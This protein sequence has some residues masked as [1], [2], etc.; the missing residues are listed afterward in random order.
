M[1]DEEVL[2][3]TQVA[4]M[5]R[6]SRNSVLNLA[7]KNKLKHFKIGIQYRFVKSNVERFMGI[8]K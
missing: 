6:C 2:T 5:L 3:I 4:I 8:T 7:R 1:N